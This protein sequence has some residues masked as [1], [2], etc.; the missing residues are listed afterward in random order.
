M[1]DTGLSIQRRAMLLKGSS[2]T[3]LRTLWA[4]GTERE[5]SFAVTQKTFCFWPAG[6]WVMK[7]EWGGLHGTVPKKG[8]HHFITDRWQRL[9]LRE[10]R[11]GRSA[12][13]VGKRRHITQTRNVFERL[14]EKKLSKKENYADMDGKRRVVHDKMAGDQVF[15]HNTFWLQQSA[16]ATQQGNFFFLKLFFRGS[17]WNVICQS[18]DSMR[19][20]TLVSDRFNDS[21]VEASRDLNNSNAALLQLWRKREREQGGNTTKRERK[22]VQPWRTVDNSVNL[23]RYLYI[24]IHV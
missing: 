15:T 14:W 3:W 16:Y 8:R 11:E 18:A 20:V 23:I 17:A 6:C 1:N 9:A 10:K 13:K 12:W 21:L 5:S 2:S 4:L 22:N 24:Y 7:L 19:A